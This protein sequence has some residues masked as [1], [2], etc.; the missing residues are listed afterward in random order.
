MNIRQAVKIDLDNKKF[1]KI[2]L[3]ASLPAKEIYLNQGY[4]EIEF[5]SIL[6]Q[7][8]DYLCYDTMEKSS[9]LPLLNICK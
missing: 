5:H 3:D 1:N 4:K 7:N 2:R 6:T 8:G 9:I